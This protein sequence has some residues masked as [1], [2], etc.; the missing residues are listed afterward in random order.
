M[1]TATKTKQLTKEHGIA[2]IRWYDLNGRN[3]WG[4]WHSYPS[5]GVGASYL[6][7]DTNMCQ[8][9]LDSPVEIDGEVY[10]CITSGRAVGKR[11]DKPISF[12]EIRKWCLPEEQKAIEDIRSAEMASSYNNAMAAFRSLPETIQAELLALTSDNCGSNNKRKSAI[13]TCVHK[14]AEVV[15][16][17]INSK[18]V[19]KILD[20]IH[21]DHKY[22]PA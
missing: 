2:I 10:N 5:I 16:P 9:N 3:N 21:F 17:V 14:H 12:S 20:C 1:T 15:L 22:F 7:Y 13:Y 8:I 19:R 18:D 4:G 6:Q 11:W